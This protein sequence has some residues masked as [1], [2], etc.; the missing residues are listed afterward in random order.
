MRFK[1][2]MRTHVHPVHMYILCTRTFSIIYAHTLKFN[3]FGTNK[4]IRNN[5]DASVELV[6]SPHLK[7]R[8][9]LD[10]LVASVN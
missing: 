3:T 5:W 1:L 8:W 9:L 4:Q 2:S 10:I 7:W 6:I